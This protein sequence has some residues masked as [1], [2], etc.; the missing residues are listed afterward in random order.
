MFYKILYCGSCNDFNI[1]HLLLS[2]TS[3]CN[4]SGLDMLKMTYKF[5]A[6]FRITPNI[7]V[8]I[9]KKE[10]ST[11]SFTLLVSSVHDKNNPLL[12]N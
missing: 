9:F 6:F 11:N 8:K 5:T 4:F 7:D 12:R 10:F 1:K 3:L 2:I